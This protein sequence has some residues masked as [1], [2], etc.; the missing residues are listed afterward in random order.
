[1]KKLLF[2]ILIICYSSNIFAQYQ[3]L[4]SVT[5]GKDFRGKGKWNSTLFNAVKEDGSI[6]SVAYRVT[7]AKKL[8]IDLFNPNMSHKKQYYV[9]A[10]KNFII[11]SGK[12][13]G[14]DLILLG[15]DSDKS[16]A[17]TFKVD[18]KNE[19]LIEIREAFNF[20]GLRKAKGPSAVQFGGVFAAIAMGSAEKKRDIDI[21]GIFV[22]S[23]YGDYYV[24]SRDLKSDGNNREKHKIAVLDAEYNLVYDQEI[25]L[26]VEDKLMEMVSFN[27]DANANVVVIAKKYKDGKRK[28]GTRK[29]RGTKEANYH[30]EFI[31]INE[32]GVKVQ[33]LEEDGIFINDLTALVDNNEVFIGSYYSD[34]REGRSKGVLTSVYDLNT[35]ERTAF[36]KIPFT[37]E[38]ITDLTGATSER[39]IKKKKRKE[40]T[41]LIGHSLL[42]GSD[43]SII[44]IGEEDYVSII[45]SVNSQQGT[46]T[47]FVYHFDDILVTKITPQGELDYFRVI[48]KA[49]SSTGAYLDIHSFSSFLVNGNVHLFVNAE[50]VTEED[51]TIYFKTRK[52]KNLNLFNIQLN[53]DGDVSYKKVLKVRK[54]NNIAMGIKSATMINNQGFIT[55]GNDGKTKRYMKVQF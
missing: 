14:N 21:S 23:T 53:T 30:M 39:K 55:S 5:V 31:I 25:D 37:D 32:K 29:S 19:E 54:G 49:Q 42:I 40:N 52:E 28:E 1:M 45:N 46:R 11:H 38:V 51:G 6:Y 22:S 18:F 34:E 7:S 27:V 2:T 15:I 48:D 44:F 9:K 33:K 17:K 8:V 10:D 41:E 4:S 35:L 3:D 43:R 47:T 24:Y 12:F 50:S 26:A 36:S 20:E 13:I 16:I